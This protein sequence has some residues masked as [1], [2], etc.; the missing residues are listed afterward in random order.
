MSEITVDIWTDVVCPWCYIGKRRFESALQRFEYRDSV[1]VTWRS[2][3]L[4]PDGPRDGKLTIPQCMQ[5]DLGMSAEQA[6]AGM[7]MVTRLAAE[8]GL[9]YRLEN[10]VPVNTFDVHRLIHFGE[11]RSLGE[12]VRERLLRG[13]TAEGAYLGDRRTLARLGS[14]AGL[15]T[16]E[17]EALLDGD[18]F[19]DAVRADE[20]RAARLGVTGVPSFSFN[21]GRAVSGALSVAD[22]LGRLRHAVLPAGA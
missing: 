18:R 4:D 20:Q 5:R 3:E 2:F 19:G 11:Y 17:V 13:Y 21:G 15:D 6:A 12:P 8:V 14:E 10:A 16:A 7:A 1:A 22:I 9:E